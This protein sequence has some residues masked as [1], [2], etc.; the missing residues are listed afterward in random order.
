MAAVAGLM[1]TGPLLSPQFVIWLLPLVAIVPPA[2]NGWAKAVHRLGAAVVA[3]TAVLFL[4]LNQLLARSP[5]GLEVLLLRNA[6][7]VALTSPR[8][9]PPC[10]NC[11]RPELFAVH[12]PA[13]L[14]DR[15][16]AP[17][18]SLSSRATVRE[19]PTVLA[20][21]ETAQPSASGSIP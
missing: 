12:T 3:L 19:A 2:T 5:G 18:E 13:Q 15:R 7:L 1:A 10:V 9:S 16:N 20:V 6:A 21:S 14:G 8:R 4:L 11:D 17:T